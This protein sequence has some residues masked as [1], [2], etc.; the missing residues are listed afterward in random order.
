MDHK[1]GLE[2][3]SGWRDWFLAGHIW[4][5]HVGFIYSL[6]GETC[7]CQI[8]PIVLG[9]PFE[10]MI[11][12]WANLTAQVT[13]LK[14]S[15]VQIHWSKKRLTNIN[16]NQFDPVDLLHQT[17]TRTCG[18]SSRSSLIQSPPFPSLGQSGLIGWATLYLQ[19]GQARETRLPG[20]IF[21]S[22][23]AESSRWTVETIKLIRW[24][25]TPRS[26]F[27]FSRPKYGT[28]VDGGEKGKGSHEVEGPLSETHRP[29]WFPPSS[30]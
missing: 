15:N 30:P 22:F 26:E 25:R 27:L 23:T 13:R 17:S 28:S 12:N 8:W 16:Y 7:C 21:P 4:F 29:Q 1:G 14:K 10:W 20:T 3:V 19:S 24:H 6:F 2:P 9:F 11:E 18:F 5:Q